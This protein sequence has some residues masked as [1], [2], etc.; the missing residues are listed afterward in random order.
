[1]IPYAIAW[2]KSRGGLEAEGRA[3]PKGRQPLKT[4]CAG[5]LSLSR[6]VQRWPAKL[7]NAFVLLSL[8]FTIIR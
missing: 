6:S 5:G 4:R 3:G 1:M 2:N 8:Q 7:R